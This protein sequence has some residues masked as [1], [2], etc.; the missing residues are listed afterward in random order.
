MN[1]FSKEKIDALCKEIAYCTDKNQH[2][3]SLICLATFLEE[4]NI[5][6]ALDAVYTLHLYYAYMTSDLLN[7]RNSLSA[8]LMHQ[9]DENKRLTDID[10]KRIKSSF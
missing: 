6:H 7:I 1:N 9:L 8:T 2:T 3:E 10:K 5:L 4:Y